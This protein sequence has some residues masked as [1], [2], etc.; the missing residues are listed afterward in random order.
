MKVTDQS[1]TGG[2]GQTPLAVTKIVFFSEKDAECSEMEKYAKI[3]CDILAR[4]SVKN[5]DIFPNIFIQNK[6]F[7]SFMKNIR[8][9]PF[10]IFKYAYRKIIKKYL[11]F[12]SPQ[13]PGFCLIEGGG[14]QNFMDWS[15]T[16]IFLHT[17][18]NNQIP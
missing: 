12:K 16:Y 5:L 7:F 3:F 4:V 11:F 1:I 6:S 17:F 8:F 9:R 2:R 13:K 15:V 14:A 18:P 10:C